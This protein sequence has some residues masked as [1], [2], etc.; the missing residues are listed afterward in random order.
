MSKVPLPR[1]KVAGAGLIVI[2]IQL[3]TTL[4]DVVANRERYRALTTAARRLR[5]FSNP[6][7]A[8]PGYLLSTTCAA[9]HGAC[10]AEIARCNARSSMASALLRPLTG[11]F[12]TTSFL[13]HSLLQIMDQPP[14]IIPSVG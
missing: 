1:D 2:V 9:F 13:A 11:S 6:I 14:A 10:I 7:S 5:R 4:L 8:S 12:T 3:V